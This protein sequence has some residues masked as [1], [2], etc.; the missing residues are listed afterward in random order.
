MTRFRPSDPE[1]VHARFE[2]IK[3]RTLKRMD[4]EERE[5]WRRLEALEVSDEEPSV[6]RPPRRRRRRSAH[7]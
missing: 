3:A 5:L 7:A 4:E 1:A 2:R 6:G